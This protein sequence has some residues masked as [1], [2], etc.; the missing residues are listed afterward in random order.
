VAVL[1]TLW[2]QP[3]ASCS[4]ATRVARRAQLVPRGPPRC[5][6]TELAEGQ[7]RR[8]CGWC[9]SWANGL[10]DYSTLRPPSWAGQH[11]DFA[12]LACQAARCERG[13]EPGRSQNQCGCQLGLS[14]KRPP[15]AK[16]MS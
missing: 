16:P 8:S 2:L 1:L 10:S 14:L 7:G 6:L 12:G 4:A 11:A 9:L 3:A 5:S 15:S 13:K